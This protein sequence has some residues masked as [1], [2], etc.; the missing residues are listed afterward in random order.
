M[1]IAFIIAGAAT[2]VA[3]MVLPA[4][5]AP[6]QSIDAL[7]Q[8]FKR[9]LAIP[10][11]ANAPYS[12]QMATLGKK[13]F[14]DPRLSG[15]RNMSCATCHNPSFGYGAPVDRAVGAANAKLGRHAPTAL[16]AAWVAPLFWDGRAETLEDQAAGPITAPA[17]MNMTFETLVPELK[18]IAEYEVWFERLFPGSGVNRDNIL[19][20]IATYERTIVADWAP[21]DRWVEGDETAIGDS[22]KRGF[23]TFTGK[24]QCASCH[25][26]WNFTD[27]KFHDIGLNPADIG[28]GKYEPDNPKAQYAF[29]TPGLRNLTQRA[30][31]G[32]DGSQDNLELIVRHYESG[33]IQRPSLANEMKPFTL[34]DPERDDLVAFLRS[35]TAEKSETP[36]P[37]LP[38]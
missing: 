12:P 8:Q 27:N 13:L 1:R 38:N 30:P 19:T 34:T 36:V 35:L 4:A 7:K 2:A 20:A 23:S 14:F 6:A 18:A 11:P 33:G 26:G 21:F 17:E 22:A 24:A 28:R 9:P 25:T 5:S 15:A 31:F 16:N 10:F 32:H 37:V 3:G 29:K